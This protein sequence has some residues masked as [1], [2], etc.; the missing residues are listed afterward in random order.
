MRRN[1]LKATTLLIAYVA[2]VVL[3]R[4]DVGGDLTDTVVTIFGPIP[5]A[6]AMLALEDPRGRPIGWL[7]GIMPEVFPG[8]VAG[9]MLGLALRVAMR[10]VALAAG[11]PTS[12]TIP[13]TLTVVLIF[14]MLGGA[15]GALLTAVWRSIP[16]FRSAPGLIGGTALAFW[17]WYPF[18]LAGENDLNGLIS[19]PLVI[20]FTMLI[21]GMWIGYGMLLAALM[22]RAGSLPEPVLDD[23]SSR[24]T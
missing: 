19:A 18:F 16:G 20:L 23:A 2:W 10:L 9:A 24:S 3:L 1:S 22:R 17:F 21:S 5:L 15:Y 7:R 8:L 4:V 14:A 6:I 12:F 11:V 13:G